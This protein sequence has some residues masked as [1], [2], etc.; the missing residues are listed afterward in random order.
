MKEESEKIPEGLVNR[1]VGEKTL[2]RNEKE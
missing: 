2:T 1:N